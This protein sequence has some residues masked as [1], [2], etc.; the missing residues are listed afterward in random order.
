VSADYKLHTS[1]VRFDVL[2]GCEVK[3]LGG[4]V[5][6]DVTPVL[7]GALAQ[8]SKNVQ[9]SIDRELPDLG[10]EAARLWTELGKPRQLPLGACVV[11]A[12]E[13]ITQGP[14]SGTV[15]LAR[16]R[17]G[18]LAHPEV[19]VKCT[20]PTAAT[21]PL[22]PL[23]DDPA[24]P[25]L[26]DMHLAIVLP[27]DAPARAA[28]RADPVDFG[29]KRARVKQASGDVVAGLA[30]DLSGEVCGNVAL[31]ASGAAFTDAQSLH[32]SGCALETGEAERLAAAQLDGARLTASLE[33][34]PIGLPIAID[35]LGTM[36]PEIAHGL[37]DDKMTVSATVES[38]KPETAG[39]RGPSVVAVALLR[40]AVT[41]RAK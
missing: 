1:E 19:R 23:R 29:G 27:D 26:G 36:L 30:L 18:L 9:A 7:R 40:G 4:F 35:A 17:F 8:Q 41:L 16:L 24:L 21:K 34:A 12:P 37:S 33:K 22:P 10:P 20:N 38:S 25:A 14:A 31:T 39:L 2:K 3:A 11:L 15:D 13:E 32:L 5:T 28:E 6:V